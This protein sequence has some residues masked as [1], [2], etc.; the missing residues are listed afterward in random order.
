MAMTNPSLWT[1]RPGILWSTPRTYPTELVEKNGIFRFSTGLWRVCPH[2][3]RVL[4]GRKRGIYSGFGRILMNSTNF[5]ETSCVKLLFS[6]Q[7]STSCGKVYGK[8]TGGVRNRWKSL[9]T[10]KSFPHGQRLAANQLPL[11]SLTISSISVRKTGFCT[12]RFSTV[13][14][15]ERTVEW[16]RSMSLPMLGRDISVI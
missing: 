7:F 3:P 10:K 9:G 4:R 6:T 2:L 16:S 12:M 11:I 8:P 5:H 15:E 13:S 14:R 1:D